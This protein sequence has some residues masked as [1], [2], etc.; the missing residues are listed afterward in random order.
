MR[1]LVLRDETRCMQGCRVDASPAAI[2]Q[3]GESARGGQRCLA[4]GDHIYVDARLRMC[5]RGNGGFRPDDRRDPSSA[6]AAAS[7]CARIAASQWLVCARAAESIGHMHTPSYMCDDTR[8]LNFSAASGGPQLKDA[9]GPNDSGGLWC[10]RRRGV[11]RAPGGFPRAAA[12]IISQS[13]PGPREPASPHR[14]APF[15]GA[16]MRCSAIMMHNAPNRLGLPWD[17]ADVRR[18][19]SLHSA[20][21]HS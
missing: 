6:E 13:Q 2:K 1:G 5:S 21:G 11:L 17:C 19:C 4:G 9:A 10:A 20:A 16:H 15:R 18:A 7:T 3:I 14:P 12:K 8:R